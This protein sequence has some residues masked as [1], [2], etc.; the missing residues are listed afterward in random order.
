MGK[1]TD[2]IRPAF[3]MRNPTNVAVAVPDSFV[4]R[5]GRPRAKIYDISGKLLAILKAP[6]RS[7]RKNMDVAENATRASLYFRSGPLAISSLSPKENDCH[8]NAIIRREMLHRTVKVTVQVGMGGAAPFWCGRRARTRQ[9]EMPALASTPP[10][11]CG[12][13]FAALNYDLRGCASAVR[14]DNDYSKCGLCNNC[15]AYF[16][17][18]IAVGRTGS[19]QPNLTRAMRSRV[20]HRKDRSRDPANN[21]YDYI[22][23]EEKCYGFGGAC[24]VPGAP[25]SRSSRRRSAKTSAW[26]ATGAR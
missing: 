12:F 21:F 13:E 9:R 5:E 22:I 14:A 11:S 2:R 4:Y 18:T 16:D 10:R 17:I 19:A 25:R 6:I 26:T 23:D 15:P 20:S 1:F 3:R 24:S 7:A 8:D